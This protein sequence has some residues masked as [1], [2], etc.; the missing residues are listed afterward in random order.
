MASQIGEGFVVTPVIKKFELFQPGKTYRGEFI[1]RNNTNKKLE[2]Q[3]E[4]F[5]VDQQNGI[6]V[7]LEKGPIEFSIRK[8]LK[9]CCRTI[10][11]E[12]NSEKKVSYTIQVPS[13]VYPGG[14]YGV[15]IAKLINNKKEFNALALN[16]G[17]G[18]VIIGGVGI[19]AKRTSELLS[20]TVNKKINWCWPFK[21]TEFYLTLKNNGNIHEEISGYLYVYKKSPSDTVF[22]THLNKD[23]TVILPNVKRTY[24][25]VFKPKKILSF[26]DG[27]FVINPKGIVF[28]KYFALVRVKHFVNNKYVTDE[29]ILSFWILPWYVI[30][31]ILVLLYV[32]YK[33]INGLR[34]KNKNKR[35]KV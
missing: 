18:H 12:P 2:I 19:D 3:F 30:F 35:K 23:K 27:R 8:W 22:L 34:N 24:A 14:K 13:S 7:L 32:I 33:K 26:E 9:L 6:P 21:D 16:Q 11:L 5:D 20:F 28:G 4:Y 29:R 17:I 1:V 31:I 25:Y 10:T 15:I